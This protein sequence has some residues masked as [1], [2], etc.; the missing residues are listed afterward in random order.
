MKKL[1]LTALSGSIALASLSVYASG[2]HDISGPHTHA[3]IGVMGDHTHDAGEFMFS[4]RYMEMEMSGNLS[5][6]NGISPDEI[7]TTVSNRFGAPPTLRVVP[8]DM[9]TSM[10]MFGMMYAPTNELTLMLMANYLKKEMNHVTYMGMMG[11]NVLGNFTTETSGIGDTKLGALY[12]IHDDNGHNIHLN[13]GLSLPTGD[14]EETG[15]ILT[16]M[17]TQPTP[18]LP[19]AM[20]LGSGTYDVEL[21]ATYNYY[22]HNVNLGAQVKHLTRTGGNNDEGY[23]LGDKTSLTGWAGYRISDPVSLSARLEYTDTD[24]ISGMDPN[25]AA[26]VQT[27]DP[28]NYG[29]KLTNLGLG[30]NF[31]GQSG[32]LKGHRFALEYLST[33]DQDANGVQMEMDDMWTLGYQYAF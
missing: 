12:K 25:I 18:R 10:H 24:S 30:I 23:Q 28:D 32:S 7:V 13:F 27:A 16:P 33:I 19:Y 31:H 26:P 5:G 4:Y 1:Q 14:I 3:P 29:G 21:G 6:S 2:E 11:T 22:S 8:L 20:Q 15:Q 17:N 9:T